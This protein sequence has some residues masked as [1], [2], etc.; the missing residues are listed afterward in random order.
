[1]KPIES[2]NMIVKS[3]KLIEANY[4]L[5]NGEQK[6]LYKVLTNIHKDDKDFQEYEFKITEFLE[7]LGISSS[8]KYEEV[9]KLTASLITKRLIIYDESLNKLIQVAWLAQA[10]YY[11]G[12][13]L[14]KICFAPALKPYLLQLKS[15]FTKFDIHNIVKLRS[16]Y[17]TRI[18]ELLKQCENMN[19]KSRTFTIKELRT[20]F[21]IT[22]KEYK[23][24]N[25]FKKSIIL[26][27]YKEINKLT[28]LQFE[29]Q[30]IKLGRKVDSIKFMLKRKNIVKQPNEIQSIIDIFNSLYNG[31]LNYKLTEDMVKE[32]G[33]DY[34]KTCILDYKD[35]IINR[36]I[37]NINAD[38]YT[39]V[40]EGYNKPISSNNVTKVQ[41][42]QR[43]Y[44][45]EFYAS[46]YENADK[47]TITE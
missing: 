13:G 36:N 21:G 33:I 18:Y 3:N 30:E 27:A 34:V 5:T 1:M 22:D 4:R 9:K 23:K 14:V 39:Y 44:S 38:F 16:F 7:L 8:K 17:S 6:I 10:V 2:K 46:L 20:K 43:T 40:M 24:Y 25:D 37:K 28:D 47:K 29:F 32:K 31:D 45:D 15:E 26:Q 41:F 35:F 19:D 12:Q 11:D 42:E